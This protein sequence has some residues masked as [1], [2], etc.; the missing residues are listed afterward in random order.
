MS[1]RYL[2]THYP[3]NSKH[4]GVVRIFLP[5]CAVAST[6]SVGESSF[7]VPKIIDTPDMYP[8]CTPLVPSQKTKNTVV[9]MSRPDAQAAAKK[10]YDEQ[11]WGNA[12]AA[13]G[14]SYACTRKEIVGWTLTELPLCCPILREG[15]DVFSGRREGGI[16]GHVTLMT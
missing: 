14:R 10:M 9:E 7:A 5:L 1:T 8:S 2:S 13:D 16:P 4:K 15:L 12:D 6:H 11:V 3:A